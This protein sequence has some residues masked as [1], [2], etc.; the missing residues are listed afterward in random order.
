M[1]PFQTRVIITSYAKPVIN[2]TEL[3]LQI[4]AASRN[5]LKIMNY[6]LLLIEVNFWQPIHTL[7][8]GKCV[9]WL[10]Y[11][12]HYSF[13]FWAEL[14]SNFNLPLFIGKQELTSITKPISF[15]DWLRWLKLA[16]ITALMDAEVTKIA[17]DDLIVYFLVIL[18]AN[19]TSLRIYITFKENLLVELS[20]SS[21][22]FI[23]WE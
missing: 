22:G 15:R 8:V 17:V 23:N 13:H 6:F 7:D 11:L 5:P 18:E 4:N 16:P 14:T 12:L 21:Q 1:K 2:L 3:A 20:Q 10:A 19:V 9:P